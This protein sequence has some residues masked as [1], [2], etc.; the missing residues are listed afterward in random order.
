MCVLFF[1]IRLTCNFPYSSEMTERTVYDI[2]IVDGNDMS[3]SHYNFRELQ[4]A[5]YI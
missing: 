1:Q 3:H 2:P 5:E 4:C